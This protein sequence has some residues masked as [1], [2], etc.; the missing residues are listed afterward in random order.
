MRFSY[1][2]IL[3]KL[4]PD[5]FSFTGSFYSS[6]L[7]SSLS[8]SFFF[9][10]FCLS[11]GTLGGSYTFGRLSIS[12][13]FSYSLSFPGPGSGSPPPS[14]KLFYNSG[15]SNS[16]SPSDTSIGVVGSFGSYSGGI[17]SSDIIPRPG[18]ISKSSIDGSYKPNPCEPIS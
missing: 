5:F 9:F 13:K 2:K 14:G 11:A 7:S 4:N 18:M 6:Y 17:S 10:F 12:S 15:S 8:S 16:S 1:V 3:L